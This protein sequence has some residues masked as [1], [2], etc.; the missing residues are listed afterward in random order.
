MVYN[1]R[2][3]YLLVPIATLVVFGVLA[4]LGF[5]TGEAFYLAFTFGITVGAIVAIT[6]RERAITGVL[7]FGT[8]LLALA[9][10]P[11]IT[12]VPSTTLVVTTPTA[13]IEIP[14]SMIPWVCL[15]L[16]A[17]MAVSVAVGAS[18]GSMSL[19]ILSIVLVLLYYVLTDP[20]L[21]LFSI[22]LVGVIASYPL[23]STRYSLLVPVALG[24]KGTT[25]QINI[26][27]I[28]PYAVLL[29]PILTFITL[30]P[31]NAIKKRVYKDMAAVITVFVVLLHVIDL[32][33]AT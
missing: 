21:K 5:S 22:I 9:V 23:L 12:G 29:L 7:A 8:L 26:A 16:I 31:F 2:L 24:S 18:P 3:G 27:E 11:H 13:Q 4:Y 25:Y 6:E 17:F 30:D 1:T 20:L 28:N 15:G 19:W 33:L 14:T 10:L 32:F